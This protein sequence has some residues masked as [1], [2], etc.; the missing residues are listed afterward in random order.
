[1]CIYLKEFYLGTP[2]NWYEYMWI[3]MADIFQ[4]IINQYGLTS[5]AVNEKVLVEIRKSMYRLKQAGRIA[6]NRL[7][8][9]L[10]AS[11]YVT[12]KYTPGLFTHISRKISFAL[13]VDDF[14]VKYTN[15]AN[16]QHLLTCL[17]QLYKCTT[18][19]EGDLY[20]GIT[21]N[22]NYAEQW[23]EKSMPGYIDKAWTRF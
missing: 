17:G 3:K 4:D 23:M 1:M 13:C 5:K 11:G 2:M 19:W 14:G 16:A 18:Y 6:N 12:C 15:K 20:L 21:L 9:H 8:R 7:K 22:W 10:K